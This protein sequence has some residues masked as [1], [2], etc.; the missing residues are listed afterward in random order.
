MYKR[1]D[2]ALEAAAD[3]SVHTLSQYLLPL[4]DT[5][6]QLAGDS[7]TLHLVPL[8]MST[9]REHWPEPAPHNTAYQQDLHAM[10]DDLARLRDLLL[11]PDLLRNRYT[12]PRPDTEGSRHK[13]E[14]Q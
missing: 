2:L 5:L 4:E 11:T 3:L 14:H 9:F 6:T 8:R 13:R 1:L 10:L 7:R 12:P